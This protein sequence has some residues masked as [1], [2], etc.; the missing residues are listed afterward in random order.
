MNA[1]GLRQD[2]IGK[3]F[4]PSN[5]VTMVRER[6]HTISVQNKFVRETVVELRQMISEL[7]HL[8][9]LTA[10]GELTASLAHE[11][12]QPT[13]AAR[14]NAGAAI[15]FLRRRSPDL[16]E[17]SEAL[18]C[19]VNDIAR[20]AAIVDRIRGFL[21]KAP[22]RTTRFDLNE[23]V[24]EVIGITKA[25]LAQNGVCIRARFAGRTCPVHGDRIQV[26]QVVLNLILNAVDA[27]NSAD[28]TQRELTI[29][30]ERCLADMVVVVIG[31]SGPGIDD[32]C[33]ERVFQ[34]FY[35]TKNNGLGVGLSI[36]R[37]IINLHGGRLWAEPNVPRGAAFWFTLPANGTRD[38]VSASATRRR[39]GVAELR[40]TSREPNARVRETEPHFLS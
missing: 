31:D 4:V 28:V 9:R 25:T 33:L 6:A 8:N 38:H 20:A 39:P 21:K 15:R 5:P 18:G 11:I 27:M 2:N 3:T 17:I 36:C 35:T 13:A 19:V 32:E 12:S 37:S 30:V 26:Q 10:M 1:I 34:P 23:A 14:I 7:A 24:I 40:R 16:A 22:S 29:N